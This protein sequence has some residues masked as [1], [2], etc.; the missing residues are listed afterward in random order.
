MKKRLGTKTLGMKELGMKH[1]EVGDS[2][3]QRGNLLQ[4]VRDGETTG[5]CVHGKT[6]KHSQQ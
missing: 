4:G 6:R 3:H 2:D 5:L 1:I